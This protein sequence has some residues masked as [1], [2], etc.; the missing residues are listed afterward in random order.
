MKRAAADRAVWRT[1]EAGNKLLA[2]GFAAERR[3]GISDQA[4]PS[5]TQAGPY[6]VPAGESEADAG[7][8][9]KWF[10]QHGSTTHFDV[11]DKE[12]NAVACTHSLG[13][14]F[15]SRLVVPGVGI[16][17]NSSTTGRTPTRPPRPRSRP[18]SWPQRRTSAACPRS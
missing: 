4:T 18:G 3:A 9:L 8:P 1:E 10:A 6:A 13:G 16:C 7:D 17:L 12:G 5:V 14:G 15:G 2:K 11:V